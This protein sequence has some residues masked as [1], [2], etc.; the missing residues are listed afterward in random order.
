MDLYPNSYNTRIPQTRGT[1]TYDMA[2]SRSTTTRLLKELQDYTSNPNEALLHLGPINDEDLLH[3]EAVLK[4]VNGTPYEGKPPNTSL[5][6]NI[7][8]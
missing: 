3:W 7:S 6:F 4:G 2:S 5:D 1:Q 8:T